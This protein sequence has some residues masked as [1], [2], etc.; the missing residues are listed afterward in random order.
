MCGIFGIILSEGS[1]LPARLLQHTV[2]SLFR[3]SESR[4]K[5][6]SGLIVRINESIYVL[7]EPRAASRLINSPEFHGLFNE[8]I[9]KEGYTDENLRV[10]FAFFGHSRLV[11]NGRSELNANNQPVVK[12]GAAG[13]HNGII[14]N[15]A[16]IWKRFPGIRRKT[17]VDTEAL[18]SLLQMY[19]RQNKSLKKAV[20]DTFREVKGSASI[21]LMFDDLNAILL[22]SNTGSLYTCASRDGKI[23]LFASEKYILIQIISDRELADTF[24]PGQIEQVRAGTARIVSLADGAQEQ[25]GIFDN[26]PGDQP[27]MIPDKRRPAQPVRVVDLSKYLP[28]VAV[29][30]SKYRLRDDVRQDMMR[31]WE[32]LYSG[33]LNIKT[34]TRCLNTE[35]MPFIA[36]DDAGVCNYCRNYEQRKKQGYTLYKGEKAL[37]EAVA[38]HRSKNGEPDC[39]V[40][41]SGGRDSAYGLD[42]I[43]N[44]LK[45]HPIVF[46][47]DWGMVVDLARRNQARITGKMG[48]EQILI[49]ADI[50]RKR[51]NIRKN[52]EAW[53][54]RP[55]LG[56]IPILMAGDKKFYYYFHKV[57][58]QNNVNLFIFC[59]GHEYEETR[60][61]YGF[62]GI[63]HGI[64]NTHNRLT[65]ISWYK[66]L[67]LLSFYA[68]NFLLNPAY[69]NRSMIDTFVAFYSTY[70]LH[71]DYLY[72]YQYLEWDE[73]VILD[74][75]FKEFEWEVAADTKA[76]WRIDDGTAPIYNYMYMAMAGFT[77]FDDFRSF[78]IREGKLTRE[79][80]Y[81]LVKEEN[82]PRFE[83]IEWY[84][85][86]VNLDVNRAIRIINDAPRLYERNVGE[87]APV[88][89]A[90]VPSPDIMR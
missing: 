47:Y 82:R 42:Y 27:D 78:Q 28:P 50:K 63:P 48:I 76:T 68:V 86:A 65:G 1:N 12:D 49:S 32:R 36:F 64:D 83:E 25:F 33:E 55:T 71:D 35:H 90:I 2:T 7:K 51:E 80:A 60:F 79:E 10:P 20:V 38:K 89:E 22:A 73:K 21:G 5:E 57:R 62:C 31:T 19:R 13:V 59:G 70:V 23:L 85:E 8:Y 53:L 66:K 46:T 9:R 4:G 26:S 3:L 24:D 58:E 88:K 37:E 40:G 17:D 43:V 52:F 6:A 39:V 75:I 29:D 84:A 34:C 44:R 14:V 18:F 87:S 16:D 56:M 54:K 45:L 72:L 11:T 67:K 61:K 30:V 41:F 74:K 81:A 69:I 15:D 77:E